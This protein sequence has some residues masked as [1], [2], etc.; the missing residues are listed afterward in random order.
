MTISTMNTKSVTNGILLH[1]TKRSINIYKSKL[2]DLKS[3]L[4]P[5]PPQKKKKKSACTFYTDYIPIYTQ[6]KK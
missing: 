4:P 1:R 2:Y 5:P 3:K 6:P